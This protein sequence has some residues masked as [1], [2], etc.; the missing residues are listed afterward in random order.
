MNFAKNN[1]ISLRNL[2]SIISEKGE[3]D[4][5]DDDDDD[6]NNDNNIIKEQEETSFSGKN[7][8]INPLFNSDEI[9]KNK[10]Y[11]INSF[12][13]RKEMKKIAT[14]KNFFDDIKKNLNLNFRN[15]IT[16]NRR[17]SCQPPNFFQNKLFK[18]KENNENLNKSPIID[19]NTDN[20]SS[21][22]SD[23][24]I[25]EEDEQDVSAIN[26]NI[27]VLKAEI[28]L[29]NNHILNNQTRSEST[30]INNEIK[31]IQKISNESEENKQ[32][33][34]ESTKIKTI[35]EINACLLKHTYSA[36]NISFFSGDEKEEKKYLKYVD[37]ILKYFESSSRIF[38]K[39]IINLNESYKWVELRYLKKT[40]ISQKNMKKKE[41]KNDLLNKEKNNKNKNND[42]KR[43]KT[44]SIAVKNIPKNRLK[45]TDDS[46]KILLNTIM[47]IQIAVESTPDISEIRNISQF[48][49][50]MT[51]SIQTANLSKN[52]QEIFMIKEYAGIYDKRICRYCF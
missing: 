12:N 23:F 47:G 36:K 39:S 51:Y 33:F 52:K 30:E 18:A 5:D 2:F 28:S 8:K 37:K 9:R 50:S 40:I 21:E 17:Q 20:E 1:Q 26:K 10:N 3:K 31:P 16:N 29:K 7:D 27:N 46:F 32:N 48:L 19:F 11:N 14:I 15:R 22:L 41:S 4:D 24:I 35:K 44:K 25:T 13:K 38:Y 49:N 42:H 6:H 34:E 45:T 43:T